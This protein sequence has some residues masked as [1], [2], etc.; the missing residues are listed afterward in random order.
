MSGGTKQL[1][2]AH[3]GALHAIVMLWTRVEKVSST[4]LNLNHTSI[5]A[6]CSAYLKATIACDKYTSVAQALAM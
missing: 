5:N 2:H 3:T 4:V 1:K 6:R